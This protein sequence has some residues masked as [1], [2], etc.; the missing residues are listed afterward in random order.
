[1]GFKI[2]DK[3]Y[4]TIIYDEIALKKG[5]VKTDCTC[6]ARLFVGGREEEKAEFTAKV[7]NGG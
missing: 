4:K 5:F 1:M 6:S 7:S 2:I 3:G